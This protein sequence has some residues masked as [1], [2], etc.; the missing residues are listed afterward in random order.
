M[1][2]YRNLFKKRLDRDQKKF[3]YGNN[4]IERV[5]TFEYDR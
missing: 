5:I 2:D 1:T 3:I 4:K